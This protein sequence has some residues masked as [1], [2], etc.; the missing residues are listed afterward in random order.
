MGKNDNH[1]VKGKNDSL[2]IK[3]A[4]K[5]NSYKLQHLKL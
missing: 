1:F 5:E 2:R 4:D 3:Y